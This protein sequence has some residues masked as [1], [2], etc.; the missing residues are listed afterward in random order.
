MKKFTNKYLLLSLSILFFLTLTE[1]R[2]APG[3][4]TCMQNGKVVG[5]IKIFR[6]LVSHI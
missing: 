2:A 6:T 1:G 4:I 3:R 5:D